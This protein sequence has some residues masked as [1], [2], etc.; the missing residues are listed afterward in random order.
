MQLQALSPLYHKHTSCLCLVEFASTPGANFGLRFGAAFWPRIVGQIWPQLRRNALCVPSK[1][2]P[3][4]GPQSGPNFGLQ[5][6]SQRQAPR[7]GL[8]LTRAL[9]TRT[10]PAALPHRRPS[11]S[12]AP[13]A[14]KSSRKLPLLRARAGS[15][16]H[17]EAQEKPRA[18]A[19][20]RAINTQSHT[21]DDGHNARD[22][23]GM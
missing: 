14:A 6:S 4:L 10:P 12:G 3:H 7:A 23:D 2:G 8:N 5:F 16:K 9:G 11:R 18:T 21:S 1:L 17:K 13:P 15:S 22:D 20:Q 19:A